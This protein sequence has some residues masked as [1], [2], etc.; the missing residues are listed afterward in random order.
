MGACEVSGCPRAGAEYVTDHRRRCPETHKLCREHAAAARAIFG[1]P[2]P[3]TTLVTLPPKP[4][5]PMPPTLTN[6]LRRRA[7]TVVRLLRRRGEA[8]GA[9]VMIAAG[10]NRNQWAAL[11]TVMRE[12]GWLLMTGTRSSAVYTLGDVPEDLE[13]VA[14]ARRP[15][16]PMGDWLADRHD[17]ASSRLR[18]TEAALAACTDPSRRVMLTADLHAQQSVVAVLD[19][20]IEHH[21]Q[22]VTA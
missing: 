19:A 15:G 3:P 1:P 4:E 20:T 11:R 6:L 14:M 10:I 8:K 12:R 5:V 9:E 18:T 17:E 21:Q 13:S 22:M 16:D 7:I 2:P